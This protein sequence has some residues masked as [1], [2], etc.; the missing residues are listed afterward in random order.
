MQWPN[1]WSSKGEKS[2]E[3]SPAKS[4]GKV[5]DSL[6]DTAK[7]SNSSSTTPSTTSPPSKALDLD[8]HSYLTPQTIISTVILTSGCIGFY[9]F[10]RTFLRRIPV[11]TN[12][13]P[14]FFRKRSVFGK[15]TSVGDGDNFRIFHTPG[16]ILTGWGW[17]RSIPADKKALRNNTVC[18]GS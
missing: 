4:P 2:E 1:F 12:I 18:H 3:D 7:P 13:S 16:G 10:Y 8:W 5:L 9:K 15:V 6:I 17:W 14:G 11:A